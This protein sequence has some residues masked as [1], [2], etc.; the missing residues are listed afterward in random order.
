MF[1]SLKKLL[2]EK[3]PPSATATS[4]LKQRGNA[5][6]RSGEWAAAAKCYRRVLGSA[7][8]DVDA[9]VS[10]GFV[11]HQQRHFA[12]AEDTIRQAV[13]KAPGNA[14]AHYI[15][16]TIARDQG[17]LTAAI[18]HFTKAL[19]LQPELL[20]AYRDLSLAHFQTGQIAAAKEAI[21]RGIAADPASPE[22]R[23]LHGNLLSHEKDYTGAIAAYQSG[24][25]IH[26]TSPELHNNL[27]NALKELGRSGPA[28]TSYQTA[29][30]HKPGFVDA[31]INLAN[32]MHSEGRS[33]EA[34]AHFDTAISIAPE[35]IPAYLGAAEILQA[36]DKADEAL[37]YL[38][39]IEEL[40]SENPLLHFGQGKALSKLRN[41][42]E[43]ITSLQRAVSLKP[44][45]VGAHIELGNTLLQKGE[46]EKSLAAYR[47]AFE[48]DP[49]NP[50]GHLVSALSG[51]NSE[52]APDGYVASLFDWYA[53]KFDSHLVKS[54]Q[55]NMP[56]QLADLLRKT[57][58]PA[59]GS[60][61]V[62]DLGCGTGL[63]GVAIGADATHMVGV[64]LSEKMLEKAKL[65]NL[66]ARLERADLLAM[67]ERES[68][69]SY[70]IVVAADVFV[71]IGKLDGHATQAYRL[72]RP[73]GL[74]AFS[75]EALLPNAD[76][77]SAG[78]PLP[79]YRLNDTG[80][81]AH[82][83]AYI[84]RL[85][86]DN[87]FI[88]LGISDAQGRVNDGKPVAGYIGLFRR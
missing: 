75:V 55:Y 9:L 70:D 74:F 46:R 33:E 62:L 67:M 41:L 58:H 12:E 79:D 8:E 78:G 24:L 47:Q 56:Q 1:S 69:T 73:D 30:S 82:A 42:D 77:T 38:R 11:L 18:E 39:K 80:R 57:A 50:V 17:R 66:Y 48:L 21:Q 53:D 76:G 64:D 72:L 51:T 14:D 44:D 37:V 2:S 19:E 85:A 54:L 81:Y 35:S 20:D 84:Q 71:Y 36:Q 49:N 34:L 45:F 22:F 27:G 28:S 65:L 5:H 43:A 6:L 68:A 7:K 15:R 29:I 10:L 26:P 83:K 61:S 88:V 4:A 40:A 16:G 59:R 3:S 87:G 25:S 60:W 63:A 32:V 23:L 86:S 31:H 52:R 13:A